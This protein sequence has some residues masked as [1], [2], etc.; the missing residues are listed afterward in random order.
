[1]EEMLLTTILKS[2][3]D[4]AILGVLAYMYVQKEFKRIK[5]NQDRLCGQIKEMKKHAEE[6]R[7]QAIEKSIRELNSSK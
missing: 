7:L 3:G 5:S 2:G 1:M 6:T 4:T